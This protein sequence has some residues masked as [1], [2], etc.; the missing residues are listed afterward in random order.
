MACDNQFN[1][2]RTPYYSETETD[3]TMTNQT[4]MQEAGGFQACSPAGFALQPRGY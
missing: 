4:G 2:R 3:D 1:L